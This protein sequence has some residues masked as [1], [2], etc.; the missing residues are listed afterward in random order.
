M[1]K[2]ILTIALMLT[3][4]SHAS[5]TADN[6]ENTEK[7]KNKTQMSSIN[8]NSTNDQFVFKQEF[9]FSDSS[10]YFYTHEQYLKS[11]INLNYGFI[12]S[13]HFEL[14]LTG[15]SE[16]IH[17]NGVDNYSA[18]I[19][20]G[21]TYNFGGKTINEDYYF[22]VLNQVY[23]YPINLTNG[24]NFSSLKFGKRIPISEYFQYSPYIVAFK[25]YSQ[26]TAAVELVLLHFSIIF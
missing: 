12:V 11:S 25:N 23:I 8:E 24:P 22:K 6:L 9:S 14:N 15:F 18:R 21:F 16:S 1:K 5:S 7:D 2:I 20:A 19:L 4:V 26:D 13:R 17:N 3:A 10:A